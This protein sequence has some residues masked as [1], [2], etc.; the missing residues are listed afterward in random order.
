MT[1]LPPFPGDFPGTIG[2]PPDVAALTRAADVVCVVS[3]ED[4]LDDGETTYG[5]RGEAV[6]FHRQL[7]SARVERVAKGAASVSRIQVAF[8]VPDVPPSFA[9]LRPGERAIL[10]LTRGEPYELVN[11]LNAKLG[12]GAESRAALRAAADG[13]DRDVADVANSLLAALPEA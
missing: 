8:L 3:V 5:V 11:P 13:A 1:T 10:F 4:V 12:V 7:A 6:L 9:I 2:V